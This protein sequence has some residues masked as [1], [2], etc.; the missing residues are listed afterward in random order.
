MSQSE[1]RIWVKALRVLVTLVF[2]AAVLAAA[3]FAARY[4]ISHRPKP[5]RSTPTVTTPVVQ[6]V[7]AATSREQVIIP[8]MGTVIPAT[9]VTLQARVS[10]QIIARHPEFIKGGILEKGD[11][12]VEID[13]TDYELALTRA[14]AQL[15]TA[16]YEFKLEEGQQDVAKREWEIMG[17]E[18]TATEL[19]N[20]LALRKPHLRLRQSNLEAAEADL[21]QARINLSRTK[22][23]APF[24]AVVREAN[25][26]PGDQ[27]TQQVQLGRLAGTDAYW[28]E[29]SLRMDHLQWIELPHGEAAG[30]VARICTGTGALREGR[31]RKLLS[32]LE[33]QGLLARLLIEV[34]DPLCLSDAR[35]GVHPLLLGDYVSVD[36]DGRHLEGIVAIPRHALRDG[37]RV[38]LVTEE[39][40]LSVL[41][42]A[43]VWLDAER[44]LLRGLGES[45][46]V[47]VSDLAA[48]VDGMQVRL[49]DGEEEAALPSPDQSEARGEARP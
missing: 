8:A 13:P 3:G 34:E 47:I 49:R 31:V 32:D 40:R 19:D 27:A 22:V 9:E 14:L 29:V 4:L 5:H 36:I 48:P 26:D 7:L 30:S 12:L 11:V 6:T 38:W 2:A 39:A 46:R 28:I 16:R 10:G 23:E 17:A 21:A 42:P 45:A 41:E 15:E 33:P 25:V 35:A 37:N 43:V 24:N 44:A 18:D 20:E 1:T